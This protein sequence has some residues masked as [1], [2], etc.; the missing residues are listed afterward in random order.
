MGGREYGGCLTPSE[1]LELPET[2]ARMNNPSDL[3]RA[4]ERMAMGQSSPWWVYFELSSP[5]GS[6]PTKRRRDR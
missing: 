4:K 1:I 6:S 3:A 2:G 5:L